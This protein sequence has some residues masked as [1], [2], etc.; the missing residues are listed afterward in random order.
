MARVWDAVL[1]AGLALGLIF[2]VIGLVL[3]NYGLVGLGVVLALAGYFG[4]RPT[5]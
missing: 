2:I 3:G 1:P 5:E 4:R